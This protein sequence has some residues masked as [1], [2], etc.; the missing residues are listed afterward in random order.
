MQLWW[1]AREEGGAGGV[2]SYISSVH[3]YVYPYLEFSQCVTGT[4]P[5]FLIR[6]LQQLYQTL[7]SLHS[8][9]H[10][11]ISHRKCRLGIKNR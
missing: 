6:M 9:N 7:H 8:S 2:V 11:H 10:T 5:H 4:Y 3:V 1:P